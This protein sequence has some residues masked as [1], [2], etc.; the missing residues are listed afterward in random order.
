M[1]K[2]NKFIKLVRYV[3][4]QNRAKFWFALEQAEFLLKF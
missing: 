2:W 4:F 3:L 1:Q